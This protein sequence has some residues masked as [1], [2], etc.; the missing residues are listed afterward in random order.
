LRFQFFKVTGLLTTIAL[1]GC[2]SKQI[3]T[4]NNTDRYFPFGLYHQN[5]IVQVTATSPKRDFEFNCAVKQ[6]PNEFLLI[7]YN[8]FG[9]SLFRIREL[10]GVLVEEESDIEE[11]RK[12]KPFFREIFNLVKNVMSLKKQEIS[13]A[14]VYKKNTLYL[15][16][17]KD[18]KINL[19]EF[20]NSNIP[21][22]LK[23]EA[24]NKFNV[25]VKTKSYK[26]SM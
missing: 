15:P 21:R 20:D 9:F 22:R 8:S 24:A 2:A 13:E 10:N 12:N 7:G 25:D 5:V 6:L 18:I 17:N 11:I 14:Q 1:L 3:V 4:E 26:T 19:D 23:I 16:S